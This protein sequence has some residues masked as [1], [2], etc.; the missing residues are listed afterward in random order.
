MEATT[1]HEDSISDGGDPYTIAA[2]RVKGEMGDEMM[3]SDICSM[4]HIQRA[5]ED[6]GLLMFATVA[7]F[8]TETG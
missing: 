7:H 1:L 2:R 3:R 4:R 8:S 5:A 6:D